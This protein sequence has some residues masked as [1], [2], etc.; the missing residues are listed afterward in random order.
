MLQR[1]CH[2]LRSRLILTQLCL[3][4]CVPLV[5]GK[6]KSL[7]LPGNHHEKISQL[8]ASLFKVTRLKELDLSC[9]A[10]ESLE[11]RVEDTGC[12]CVEWLAF[13]MDIITP[14]VASSIGSSEALAKPYSLMHQSISRCPTAPYFS[15]INQRFTHLHSL[16][17]TFHSHTNIHEHTRARAYGH[18]LE[19]T[20]TPKHTQITET[21][22][23]THA[24]T[25]NTGR[26]FHI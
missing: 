20:H 13:G 5:A 19:M 4:G 24:H 16:T 26:A 12:Q 2:V 25:N 22:A 9:N 7:V 18:A 17:H 6:I 8:G 1:Q 3:R 21:H 23:L 10:L 14:Q 15:R 11:V